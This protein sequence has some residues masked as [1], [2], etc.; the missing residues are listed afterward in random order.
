MAAQGRAII[1]TGATG[2]I[3]EELALQQAAQGTILGL[4]GRDI[5]KLEALAARCRALG[6]RCQV[7]SIDVRDRDAMLRWIDTFDEEHPVMWCFANAGVMNGTSSTGDMESAAQIYDTIDTNL[8]GVLNT[9]LPLLPRMCARGS[10]SLVLISSMA[11]IA[12]LAH[13]PAYS[14][15]KA[16][17]LVFAQALRE[18]V[19][20]K[21]VQVVAVCPGFVRTPMARG[22]NGW[23]PLEITAKKAA[24]LILKGTAANR[25]ILAFPGIF[26]F[27]G[28]LAPFSPEWI[29]RRVMRA[30][31][32]GIDD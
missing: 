27:L 21:G 26:A 7:A 11:A 5:A 9:V 14:A 20:E 17:V 16:A 30:F 4:L 1:I 22:Y 28:W 8:N 29:N 23:R 32:A 18:A 31:K 25:A 10:G 13:Q 15:S 12:P 2:G 24:A 19:R 6:A 3:G